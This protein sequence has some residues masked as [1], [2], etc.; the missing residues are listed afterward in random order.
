MIDY[1]LDMPGAAYGVSPFVR[2]GLIAVGDGNAMDVLML[3]GDLAER[4]EGFLGEW[5][6]TVPQKC[7]NH[8]LAVRSWELDL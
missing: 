2:G 8:R 5:T 1:H 7:D 4:Y 3:V 6:T